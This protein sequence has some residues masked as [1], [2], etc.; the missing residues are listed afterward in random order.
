M[1]HKKVGPDRFS[2]FDV[3]WIQTNKQTNKQTDKPNLYIDM[4]YNYCEGVFAK[5]SNFP[6]SIVLQPDVVDVYFMNSVR[7]NN[8]FLKH[9]RFT[10]SGC[11]D[12]G[13][14]NLSLWQKLNFFIFLF[15]FK[16]SKLIW[17]TLHTI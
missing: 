8:L 15:V 2:R 9:Q 5:N 6:N 11:K 1:S 3:Y 16:Q 17:N 13:I 14:K 4:W 10:P 7:S 12:I